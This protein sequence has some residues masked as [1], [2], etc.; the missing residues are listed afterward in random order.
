[1]RASLFRNY[2]TLG[3]LIAASF[4]LRAQYDIISKEDSEKVLSFAVVEKVPVAPGCDADESNIILR[5]CFQKSILTQVAQNFKYP[6]EDRKAGI[7]GRIYVNF[8]IEKD[9][10][11][12][13]VEVVR[14]VS[15]SLD[16]EAVRV[17]KGLQIAEPAVQRGHPVRMSFT[18][19][20]NAK[21]E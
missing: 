6:K 7:Q 20:I 5:G 8:I 4:S 15:E 17:V 14:G 2:A 1:M 19:P 10:S 9:A 13:T 18:L 21:L 16:R 11:V 3:L 12:S